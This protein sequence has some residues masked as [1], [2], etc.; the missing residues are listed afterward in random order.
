MPALSSWKTPTVS[1][2]DSSSK[3]VASSIGQVRQ[4][5]LHA[6]GPADDL[7][8]A[9]E[10][11]EVGQAQEVHLQQPDGRHL[12]HGELG[13]GDGGVAVAA[14][15]GLWR[16]TCST[17][18]SREMTTPAAWVLAWRDSPSS[19]WAVSTRFRT[20]SSIS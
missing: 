8:R 10:D 13:H 16:G 5:H 9:V 15:A 4:V 20:C 11:G 6:V 19:F 2:A 18:G 14:R 3:V 17:S 7:H 12:L 1:P